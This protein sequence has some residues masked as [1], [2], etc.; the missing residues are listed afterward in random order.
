MGLFADNAVLAQ[1][2]DAAREGRSR[3]RIPCG[4]VAGIDGLRA[5]R[6]LGLDS[7]TYRFVMSP[8]AWPHTVA[9]GSGVAGRSASETVVFR[10]R[11]AEAARSYPRHA[12][13]T[14]TI[15]LAGLGLDRTDVEFVVDTLAVR[16]RH[17]IEA[18]GYFG[19]LSVVVEGHRISESSPS[20]RLVAG[21][22]LDAAVSGA[23]T[24]D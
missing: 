5:A 19:S 20:S 8:G 14:A 21:S 18:A 24:L 11:A 23:P 3:M 10:G 22:L 15:A 9:A 7:V 2:R 6:R 1:F 17:E 13:L 16:N 4:A 12:N